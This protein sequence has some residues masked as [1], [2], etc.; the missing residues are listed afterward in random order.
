MGVLSG[1]KLDSSPQLL[2]NSYLSTGFGVVFTLVKFEIE[3]DDSL[4]SSLS[5]ISFSKSS[6]LDLTEVVVVVVDAM[7]SS[8]SLVL[9]DVPPHAK[10]VVVVVDAGITSDVKVV[11]ALVD[12]GIPIDARVVIVV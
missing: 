10:V 3:S 4:T 1:I 11:V 7:D 2:L 6:Y 8:V 5:R 12:A 9:M